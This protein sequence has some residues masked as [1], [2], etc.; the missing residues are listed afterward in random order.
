MV[1]IQQFNKLYAYFINDNTRLLKERKLSPTAIINY[2]KTHTN[3][4]LFAIE[5][6]EAVGFI[7]GYLGYLGLNKHSILALFVKKGYRNKN[8]G[9]LLVNTILQQK[10]EFWTVRIRSIDFN[11][12][13]FFKKCNFHLIEELNLYQKSN[14]SFKQVK[15]MET[16]IRRANAS[17]EEINILMDIE[18]KCFEKYWFR[19]YEEWNKILNDK[20]AAIF[21]AV[22]DNHAGKI[23]GFSH[24]S[25]N[26]VNG[27]TE[28]Q[29]I[30]IATDPDHRQKGTATR[31]TAEAFKYFAKKKVKKIYL[32]TIKS[33]ENLNKMYRKWGFELFDED[34]LFGYNNK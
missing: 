18:Q 27:L 34:V 13:N 16:N 3:M 26:I 12:I 24:N 4:V 30:R 2:G 11:L 15:E 25:I 33:N 29:Y 9:S 1:V 7:F 19:S 20:N 5:K 32:S 17:K 22:L 8:I 21:V 31:L 14:T 23:I 28:G 6:K 10:K